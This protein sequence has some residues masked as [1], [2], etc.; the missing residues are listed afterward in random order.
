MLTN[1]PEPL[2]ATPPKQQKNLPVQPKKKPSPI[3]FPT[4]SEPLNKE[5]APL[6][7]VRPQDRLQAVERVPQR[8]DLRAILDGKRGGN[9]T[10]KLPNKGP[11]RNRLSTRLD[12]WQAGCVHKCNREHAPTEEPAPFIEGREPNG[13]E[14]PR[15][16]W[17]QDE[18]GRWVHDQVCTSGE[19]KD[20]VCSAESSREDE[21]QQ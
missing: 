6:T 12:P 10:P 3:K 8:Q 14:Y 11:I 5:D 7:V 15:I 2:L 13:P 16:L 17:H 18:D 1:N 9:T 4:G 19:D 20:K 21:D